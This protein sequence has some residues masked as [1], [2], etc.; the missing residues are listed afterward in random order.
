MV[1]FLLLV[2]HIDGSF[3]KAKK[4]NTTHTGKK[5]SFFWLT[6]AKGHKVLSQSNIVELK[7]FNVY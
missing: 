3:R 6:V 4:P 2:L 7:I 1:R 5:P